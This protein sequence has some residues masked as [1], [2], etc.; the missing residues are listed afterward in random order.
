MSDDTAYDPKRN[1]MADE[2]TT[3]EATDSNGSGPTPKRYFGRRAADPKGLYA[4]APVRFGNLAPRVEY[5]SMFPEIFDQG[6]YGTCVANSAAEIQEAYLW[7]RRRRRV[8][9]SRMA[10][11]ARGRK[12]YD[13]TLTESEGGMN[14]SDG[15]KV[16]QFDGYIEEN[17]WPYIAANQFIVPPPTAWNRSYFITE[18]AEVAA[19]VD[20]IK[21]ALYHHGPVII[22]YLFPQ[23]WEQATD[24][25]LLPTPEEFPSPNSGHCSIIT[26]YDDAKGAFTLR[27][28][29]GTAWADAG[30]GYAVYEDM[31]RLIDNAY[32]IVAP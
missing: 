27:N 23:A 25:G 26:G 10:I 31:V 9:V 8:R 11:Y 6:Q 28:S 1:D 18:F 22:G 17:R 24:A 4:A 3:R 30:N 19:T 20:A 2:T 16:L 15:L 5:A 32:T 14:V 7:K 13:P 21:N 12:D 29:W